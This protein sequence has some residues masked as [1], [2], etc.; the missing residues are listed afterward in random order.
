M[1]HLLRCRRTFICA[2]AIAVL[3][4]LGLRGTDTAGAIA[5]VAAA[6]AGA[7]AWQGKPN[8]T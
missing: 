4:I 3:F 8:V 2:L 6:L 1:I 5:A 7:N